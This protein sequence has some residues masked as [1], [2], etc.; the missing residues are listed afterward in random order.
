L[1]CGGV[2]K[3]SRRVCVVRAG[4]FVVYKFIA[5]IRQPAALKMLDFR[6][7]EPTDN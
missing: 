3:N 1:A 5:I 2:N 4:L 7:V 6:P